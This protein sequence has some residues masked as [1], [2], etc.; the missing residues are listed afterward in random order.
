MM[1]DKMKDTIRKEYYKRVRQI[2]LSTLNGGITISAINSRVVSLVRYEAGV[3][4][5]T[6]EE[7]RV[8]DRKTRK[9]MTMNRMHHPRSD[10]D[11]L[12][13][14]RKEGGRMDV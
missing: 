8:T 6:K 2:C 5:W 10:I 4:K 7:L 14:P 1:H 11:R 12:Y 13:I 3:L 9:I